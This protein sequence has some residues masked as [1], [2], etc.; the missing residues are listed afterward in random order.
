MAGA[1]PNSPEAR[2][3]HYR[4][5][6]AELRHLAEKLAATDV[7]PQ[8]LLNLAEDFEELADSLGQTRLGS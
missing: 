3:A 8:Q 4:E 6:A 1:T 5:R 7:N 2:A